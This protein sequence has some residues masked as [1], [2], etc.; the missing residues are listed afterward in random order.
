MKKFQFS[1]IFL[2]SG[3]S[4]VLAQVG[5][6]TSLP[7]STLDI[8]AKN[9][10]GTS[11]GVDGLLI[12]RV[13]RERAQ[14]MTSVPISTLIFINSI[15]TG[16]S[17]G[18]AINI[19]ATGYYYF[20]GTA[21]V[22]LG[23]SNFYNSNGRLAG[24]RIVTT[25]GNPI[26]FMNDMTS[27]GIVASSVLGTLSANG[28]SRG[29]L[30]LTGGSSHLDLYVDDNNQAQ[31]NSYGNS[32][33][34]SIGT[35]ND[36]A[37]ALK[38][39]DREKII[40]LGNG[41]VGIGTNTPGSKFEIA[42]GNANISGLRFTNLTSASPTGT[43]QSIGVDTN[44]NI[45]TVAN[46]SPAS[47]NTATVNNT[48]GIDFN[49]NDLAATVVT[50][51]SQS[52]TIPSGGKTLF[53][54]FMLGIDYTGTPE[55]G[56]KATYEARLYIDGVATDCYLRTQETSAGTN[57][58]FTINTVK[59]LNT[60]NHTLDVRMIRAVNNGTTSGVTMTCRPISMSFNASYIN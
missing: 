10:T 12:P 50:G 28:S 17:A 44:G 36:A 37:L 25:N 32:T 47:I 27:V 55:G 49:V 45:I 34:L 24:T 16:T 29:S 40:I 26:V 4:L 7:L 43:G 60:G 46:P 58:Q 21:W 1:I 57:T 59:F 54:N 3:I 41:N 9:S 56:G 14:S 13:D 52:I 22:K 15:S 42:S 2:L 11:N 35:T 19:D 8:N 33:Q 23:T 6:H 18:T 30:S 31:I 53:I 5:I 38:T 48:N 39:N 51:T 20:S